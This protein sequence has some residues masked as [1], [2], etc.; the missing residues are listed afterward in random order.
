MTH[1]SRKEIA[2][3]IAAV[4]GIPIAFGIGVMLQAHI[5][6]E[7]HEDVCPEPSGSRCWERYY[8]EFMRDHS[9][10]EALQD[11]KS[12]YERG[13]GARTYCHPVLHV[14]GARA[15][16]EYG[17]VAEAYAH[18][19]TVCRSGYYH[20]VLEGLFVENGGEEM[21]ARLDELCAAVRGD[22]Y[23]YNYFSCVHGIGHGLMAYFGHDLFASLD[24]CTRLS[25]EWEQSSCAG[26]VFMENVISDTEELPSKFFKD[27]DL[28]YPCTVVTGAFATQCYLMQ[29]SHILD[30]VGADFART[31]EACRSAGIHAATCFQSIGRD[32]SGWSY[33]DINTSLTL[34]GLGESLEERK[35]CAIGAAADYLQSY[36]E[37]RARQLCARTEEG[38]SMPCDDMLR[39]QSAAMR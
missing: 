20:G 18:G 15:G 25:G 22:G 10:V 21:V 26:G 36:G 39:W 38:I 28:L 31:F 19:D 6:H 35:N 1:V 14:I 23:T 5:V 30:V 16:E 37:A 17:S 13:G 27:D 33:G 3:L 9:A 7:D 11:L 8:T 34:C 29:T 24:A 4:L 2:A 32:V 12:R